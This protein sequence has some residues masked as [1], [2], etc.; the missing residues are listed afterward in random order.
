MGRPRKWESDAERKRA[1]RG[2]PEPAV[3]NLPKTPAWPVPKEPIE[4]PQETVL[5]VPDVQ[6]IQTDPTAT[7]VAEN[8]PETSSRQARISEADYIA[9]EVEQTRLA[10]SRGLQDHDGKRVDRARAYARSRYRGFL[11]GEVASL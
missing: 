6:V 4:L 2:A 5:L 7:L 9:A 1:E 8:L 11:A 3:G 10:I